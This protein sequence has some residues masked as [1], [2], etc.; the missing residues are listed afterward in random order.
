[1]E[2]YRG[3]TWGRIRDIL[4]SANLEITEDQLYEAEQERERGGTARGKPISRILPLFDII[5]RYIHSQQ[6]VPSAYVPKRLSLR[7]Y[8]A[9]KRRR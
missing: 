5:R 7:A 8:G 2:V 3:L 6:Q 1:M 9:P 4:R